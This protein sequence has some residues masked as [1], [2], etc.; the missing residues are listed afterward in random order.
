M[1]SAFISCFIFSASAK[2]SIK[3][4][5]TQ[6]V[7]CD[8]VD[9]AKHFQEYKTLTRYG[10]SDAMYTLA[11]MYRIGYGTEIDS[12]LSIR[13]YRRA[14]KLGNPFAQYKAA[15]IYLQE[16]EIQ[17]IDKAMR[18]LR[19]ANRSDLNQAAHL[20]GMLYLEGEL[21]EKNTEKAKEYLTKSYQAGY[22][23]T[24][25]V[26]ADLSYAKLGVLQESSA[27]KPASK[28]QA[29]LT[30]TTRDTPKVTAPKGEMEV[31]EVRAP[32]IEEVFTYHISLLRNKRPDG[33]TATGTRIRGRGCGEMIACNTESD[34]MRIREFLMSTW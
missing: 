17:D 25:D 34:Q 24:I 27:T 8:S 29:E 16:S 2:V 23:P 7:P 21:I 6:L 20:L 28:A 9:C 26:L 11:E 4:L 31:I 15:I 13:W 12:R 1:L 30:A 19:D 18:Y 14:A 10:H 5:P 32:S 33:G 3:A 22:Q